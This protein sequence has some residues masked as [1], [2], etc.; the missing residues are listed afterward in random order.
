VAENIKVSSGQIDP[1]LK[2]S[3][4]PIKGLE[5][6]AYNLYTPCQ[7]K[8]WKTAKR[9]FI[10][11]MLLIF[12]ALCL[13]GACSSSKTAKSQTPPKSEKIVSDETLVSMGEDEVRKKLGEPTT[14]SKM[15]DS[16]ILWTY[17]PS[18]KFMPDNRGTIYVEF[19]GGKAV[20][21]IRVR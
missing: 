14:V 19:E 4:C 2:G 18:W 10:L 7:Q 17:T 20:K 11:K 21:I 15:S 6:S 3:S 13:C 12:V 5:T 1:E 8:L 16:R 9:P